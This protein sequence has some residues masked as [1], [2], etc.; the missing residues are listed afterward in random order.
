MTVGIVFDLHSAWPWRPGDP[1]DADAEYEPEETVEAIE[2]AL[3]ALG[4]QPLRLG[5]PR[6]LLRDGPRD[7]D[8]AVNIAEGAWS[9][10]REGWA[11]TL[12]EMWGVPFTGSDALALSISL[13]KV[14]TKQ[15]AGV[16]TPA[17]TTVAPGEEPRTPGPY[18]L[19]VKPRFEG[20]AKGIRPSSVVSDAGSLA[21]EVAHIHATY[22]QDALVE[23][24]VQ[25]GG[26]YTV[27]VVGCPPQALP[28]LQR[29]VD[30]D[31]GIGSHALERHGVEGW[32]LE[33]S[34]DPDLEEEMQ[35]MSL[36]VFRALGCRDFARVDFRVDAN[37]TPWF[38]EINPLPTFAPDGTFAVL[39]ELMG[40]SYPVWLAGVLEQALDRAMREAGPNYVQHATT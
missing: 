30:P 19:F 39:A 35:V 5:T 11:P 37:G 10:N 9:R 34:I 36:Q 22:D 33:G 4:H 6:D 25:G 28:K 21:R 38:L 29:A 32:T 17:W 26:E 12:L 2:E 13:D 23:T 18:P 14:Y 7:V 40:Q 3:R 27:A 15:I 1:P 20:T 8:A 24:F 16:R 31:T